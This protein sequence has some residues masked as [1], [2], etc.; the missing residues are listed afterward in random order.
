P[1]KALINMAGEGLAGDVLIPNILRRGKLTIS[2]LTQSASP[3]VGRE[4]LTELQ[5]QFN[6]RYGDF[7]DFLYGWSKQVKRSSISS[8]EKE[9]FVK[10]ILNDKYLKISKQNEVRKWLSALK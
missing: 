3:K 8:E 5:Q 7:V 10:Q 6:C 2:G 9:R 4:I 1:D